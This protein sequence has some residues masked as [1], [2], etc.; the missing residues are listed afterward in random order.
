ME[1][2][3]SDL[4]KF[5]RHSRQKLADMSSIQPMMMMR[6]RRRRMTLI[7]PLERANIDFCCDLEME[8]EWP[9]IRFI[10]LHLSSFN[11]HSQPPSNQDHAM[12]EVQ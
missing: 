10:I 7:P 11:T 1:S 3:S 6:R 12:T 5:I 4:F 8:V 2:C 9:T